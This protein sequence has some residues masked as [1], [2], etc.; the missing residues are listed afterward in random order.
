MTARA[1]ARDRQRDMWWGAS[2]V[3]CTTIV[4][5]AIS[6]AACAA[7]NAPSPVTLPNVGTEA[8]DGGGQVIAG[9]GATFAV[10]LP[11]EPSQG[12]S[13]PELD[14]GRAQV[15]Q[16]LGIDPW[17]PNSVAA[18]AA[19]RD[20]SIVMSWGIVDPARLRELLATPD[21]PTRATA[22][23]IR[24][25]VSLPVIDASAALA[26]LERLQIGPR[27]ARPS[28][29]Q[30]LWRQWLDR[31]AST[32]ERRAAESAGAAYLCASEGQA[33]VARVN[34]ARREIRWVVAMGIGETF[35]AATNPFSSD[36]ELAD[37]L[38]RE[39]F[40][41]ARTAY[42]TTPPDEARMFAASNLLNVLSFVPRL[43]ASERQ[44]VWSVAVRELGTP[45]G[46]VESPPRLF[47]ETFR[48]DDVTSWT[49]TAEGEALF[50]SLSLD[51]PA[52]LVAARLARAVHPAGPFASE[53]ELKRKV[54]EAGI[55]AVS[56]AHHFL[57]P[58]LVAFAAAHPNAGPVFPVPFSHPPARLELD[59]G[60]HRL[61]G[62]QM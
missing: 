3:R 20:R 31:L 46:L 23:A 12:P 35:V 6:A 39:G 4:L 34:R 25:R 14:I 21:P 32:D 44:I 30:R 41:A 58:H 26:G 1:V 13:L 36:P 50:S 48:V 55:G 56:L 45:A 62:R 40:F 17:D 19:D 59:R 60:R 57:W 10:R 54:E 28:G 7:T 27:C 2:G 29:D 33:V 61:V 9:A 52:D 38:T 49:L 11:A 47:S 5:T 15:R 53:P 8:D 51:P 18:F 43:D 22:F 42:Y 24:F 16:T 37:R